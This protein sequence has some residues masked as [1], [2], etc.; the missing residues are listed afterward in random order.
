[1][2]ALIN[3]DLGERVW[4]FVREHW[5]EEN[6]RYP[7]SSIIGLASCVR[8]LTTP[9]AEADVAAFFAKHEIPQ[10]KLM[11]QQTLE[12]QRNAV[13]LRKRVTPEL[14]AFFS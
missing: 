14:N 4:A 7:E 5:E 8:Y 1:V 3:R 11:L 2:R 13:A 9:E 10:A 12:R 6:A